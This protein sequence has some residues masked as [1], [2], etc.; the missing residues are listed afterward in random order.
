ML[1][2]PSLA[3]ANCN[4][5]ADLLH[6]TKCATPSFDV[7]HLSH[8]FKKLDYLGA[9]CA[10]YDRIYTRSLKNVYVV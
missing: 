8:L 6:Q 4:N 10:L 5:K 3:L 7:K 1:N 2:K 9:A